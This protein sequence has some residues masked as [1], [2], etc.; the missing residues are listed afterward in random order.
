MKTDGIVI[1]N[2]AA[3]QGSA[4]DKITA[5]RSLFESHGLEFHFELT[6]GPGHATQLAESAADEGVPTVVAGGGDGTCNE[7]INGLMRAA[8]RSVKTPTLAVLC[9]GRGNDF[10]YGAGMPHSVEST[11]A[12][13]RSGHRRVIDVG[14]LRG[15]EYPEGRY[16]GNGI[17]IGFDTIVGF[18][19]AKLRRIKG[20]AAYLVGA[21]STLIH[22]Y[23]APLLKLI[24][25]DG[26]SA[27]EKE[28]LQISVMIGRRMGGAFFMAPHAESDDGLFDLCVAGTPSRLRMIG[29]I[30]KYMRGTQAGSPNIWM[31][32]TR[33]LTIEAL[34]GTMAVHAD[35][36]TI[37][38]EGVR[39]EVTCL[40][41]KLPI[42]CEDE[43]DR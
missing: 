12:A 36:E 7:V 20:F 9:V 24:H 23:D 10:A 17:G 43:R 8:E 29:L 27:E 38:T 39:L 5:V 13:I 21:V 28:C 30:L 11:V 26:T 22:Y 6:R 25:E 1:Y 34:Q 16:F 3:G 14:H 35:G 40:P 2:P 32:R 15:G 41:Q 18:E 19:A 31:S 42:V 4:F 37:A 33:A